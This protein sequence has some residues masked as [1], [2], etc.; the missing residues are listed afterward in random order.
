MSVKLPPLNLVVQNGPTPGQVFTIDNS[1]QTIGRGEGCDIFIADP[2]LSRQH[3]QIRVTPNGYVLEDLGSTNGSFVNERPVPGGILLA[4]GDVI[5]L[6]ATLS[7]RVEY[8]FEPKA[9]M[10]AVDSAAPMPPAAPASQARLGPRAFGLW[11]LGI[12]AGLLIILFLVAG[13]VYFR[14]APQAEP[15]T[16]TLVAALPSPALAD[17]ATPTVET[18]TPAG[19]PPTATALQ[20]PGLAAVAAKQ[21]AFPAGALNKVDP[22]CKRKIEASATVPIFMTWQEQ[23]AEADDE[24]DYVAQWLN[25][26]YYEVSLDGRPITEI[27]YQRDDSTLD[28]W[29]YLG[30][31]PAGSHYLSIRRYASRPISTGLDV[32]PADGKPDVFGPGLA[33]EGFCEIAVPEIIAAATPTPEPTSTPQPTPTPIPQVQPP[34]RSTD[35]PIPTSSPT[36]Q[37]PTPVPPNPPSIEAYVTEKSDCIVY[38]WN[39]QN[40]KEVYFDGKGVAGN[41][42]HWDC[43]GNGNDNNGNDNNGNDNNS[44]DNNSNDNDNGNG[45]D[46]D[47]NN[48][49]GDVS[50]PTLRIIHLDGRVEDISLEPDSDNPYWRD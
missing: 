1:P 43:D 6:G 3:A 2:S 37:A 24:T 13:L 25:S 16:P 18:P 4:P 11:L 31:L 38:V 14:F 35:T 28:W 46:N 15:P 34:P 42:Q 41:G 36:V 9:T 48:D 5:R 40:V 50:N 39:I 17:T 23:L 20:V 44:N 19:P 26:V 29:G 22:F 21:Q 10:S 12:A 45:N 33:G 27:N 30:I 49:D 47:N 7:F 32:E 8:G